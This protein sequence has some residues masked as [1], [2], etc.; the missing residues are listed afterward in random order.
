MVDR[1]KSS[2]DAVKNCEERFG[3]EEVGR[4]GEECGRRMEKQSGE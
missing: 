4:S 1:A 3:K 2:V